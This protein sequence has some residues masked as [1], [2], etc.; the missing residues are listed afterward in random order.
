LFPGDAAVLAIRRV[1]QLFL[2]AAQ[3]HDG[4]VWRGGDQHLKL[5][6]G[7]IIL[8]DSREV[9]LTAITV[10]DDSLRVLT[11]LHA[12]YDSDYWGNHRIALLFGRLLPLL[13]TA[14]HGIRKVFRE[15]IRLNNG[16]RIASHR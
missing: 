14:L 7:G 1:A 3:V 5:L 4:S 10:A 15:T 12:D 13:L 6:L 2:G 9:A 11:A 8:R 16:D